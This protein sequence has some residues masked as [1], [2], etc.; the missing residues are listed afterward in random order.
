MNK[1]TRSTITLCPA[2]DARI[3]FSRRPNLGDVIVCHECDETLK[4]ISLTP[5]KL[6]WSFMDDDESWSDLD[7]DEYDDDDDYD[8]DES[9]NWD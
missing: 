2:C 7:Y 6:D 5:L 8:R 9:Y 4:V 1:D 3:H